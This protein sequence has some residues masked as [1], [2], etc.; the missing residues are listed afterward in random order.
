MK[1]PISRLPRLRQGRPIKFQEANAADTV[2]L[3]SGVN[4]G[5]VVKVLAAVDAL[6][7]HLNVSANDLVCHEDMPVVAP[8]FDGTDANRVESTRKLAGEVAADPRL[9]YLREALHLGD[10][11]TSRTGAPAHQ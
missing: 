2:A 11:F 7:K 10:R 9:E 1:H 3:L 8:K 5:S 4:L 6:S